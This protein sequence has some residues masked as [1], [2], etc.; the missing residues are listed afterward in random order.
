MTEIL[1]FSFFLQDNRK[2]GPIGSRLAVSFGLRPGLGDVLITDVRFLSIEFNAVPALFVLL[3]DLDHIA[4][5]EL[6]QNVIGGGGVRGGAD[7]E[8]GR[9]S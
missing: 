3:K 7:V 4:V 6:T 2:G 1:H 8:G 9:F 5:A